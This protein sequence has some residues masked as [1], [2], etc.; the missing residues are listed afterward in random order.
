M[1]RLGSAIAKGLDDPKVWAALAAQGV[2]KKEGGP[3][4][5]RAYL[6]AELSKWEGIVK[7][8]GATAK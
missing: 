4:E 6:A 2:E 3:D 1:E 5:T 8:S 7:Q